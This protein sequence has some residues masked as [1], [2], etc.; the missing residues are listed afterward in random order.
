MLGNGLGGLSGPAIKPIAL[1]AVYQVASA[2]DTPVVGIGGI[3]NID[4]VMEFLVA[5]ASAVQVGTA[6]F[7]DPTVS[8]RLIDQLPAALAELGVT[9]VRDAVGTLQMNDSVAA[10]T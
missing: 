6:N 2:V 7:Y 5:G 1:R 3:A 4:D 10:K 8:V 9:C